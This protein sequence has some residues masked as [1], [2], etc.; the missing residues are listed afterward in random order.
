MILIPIIIYIL[1]VGFLVS[2]MKH[3]EDGT[4]LVIFAIVIGVFI[5]GATYAGG[6]CDAHGD[7]QEINQYAID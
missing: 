1:F 4:L 5:L 7:C 2:K 6:G 3:Q